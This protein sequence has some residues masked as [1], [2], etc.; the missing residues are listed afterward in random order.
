MA[1]ACKICGET[2]ALKL[3]PFNALRC[4]DCHNAYRRLK[5]GTGLKANPVDVRVW[6]YYAKQGEELPPLKE[7]PKVEEAKAEP[8]VETAGLT[9]RIELEEQA[10]ARWVENIDATL[11]AQAARILA[12]EGEK[13]ELVER[14]ATLEAEKA[15]REEEMVTVR[16][17]LKDLAYWVL[18]GPG[19]KPEDVKERLVA[20]RDS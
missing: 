17:L 14:V 18:S 5:R 12:L 3:T 8:R 4:R 1:S 7:L 2:D 10:R 9:R 16:V 13:A 6:A 11:N 20:A 15:A 19:R